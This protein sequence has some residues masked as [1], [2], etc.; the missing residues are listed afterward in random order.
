M[1]TVG[2]AQAQDMAALSTVLSEIQKNLAPYTSKVL[3]QM[4]AEEQIANPSTEGLANNGA[5]Q[6]R[7]DVVRLLDRI[8]EY[9]TRTE[10][11]SPLPFLL[12]RAQRLAEMDFLEIV[13]ELTPSMRA[14]L[15]PI[16][17]VKP[18]DE[19]SSPPT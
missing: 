18:A 5:I 1:E 8:C 10:P 14:L 12:R 17:G 11:S 9:Y 16:V 6:S 7:Q 4:Q 19:T 15:E 3:G 2:P 13:D